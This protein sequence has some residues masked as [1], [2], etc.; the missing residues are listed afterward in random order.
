M[1]C[2][3]SF[4]VY[5]HAYRLPVY[6]KVWGFYLSVGFI[7]WFRMNAKQKAIA[8][9]ILD[10]FMDCFAPS[11]NEVGPAVKRFKI[12]NLSGLEP[13]DEDFLQ[14]LFQNSTFLKLVIPEFSSRHHQLIAMLMKEE[15]SLHA[16]GGCGLITRT[17][18]FNWRQ[19]FDSLHEPDAW[20]KQRDG[21]ILYTST[22]N[23]TLEGGSKDIN[24][25]G[26]DMQDEEPS[27]SE[28]DEIA[29]VRKEFNEKINLDM[30]VRLTENKDSIV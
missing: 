13:L 3:F 8:G 20:E 11:W 25:D 6:I 17:I 9:Y 12:E 1:T 15:Y 24:S 21:Q 10:Y 4:A 18:C 26:R 23:L 29:N 28:V 22:N 5:T 2:I 19:C 16:C 7:A 30:E 14:I 27:V